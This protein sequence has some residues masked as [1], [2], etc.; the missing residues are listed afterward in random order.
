MA[1]VH[2][3]QLQVDADADWSEK[4]RR[5]SKGLQNKTVML[6]GRQILEVNQ[7]SYRLVDNIRN[8]YS[9]FGLL[10]NPS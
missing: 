6:Y 10:D 2:F 8:E 5:R 3:F 4:Y 1:A 7:V 9:R